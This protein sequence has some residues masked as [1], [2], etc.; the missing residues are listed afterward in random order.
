MDN[1]FKEKYGEWAVVTG[2]SSGIGV[3]FSHQIAARGLNVVLVARRK[4]LLQE[5]SAILIEK[6]KIEVRII[7][8]DLSID[9]FQTAI[10]EG[11]ND[12]DVGLLVNNA[13]IN[14]EGQV[15]RRSLERNLQMI[16]VNMKAPYILAYEYGKIFTKKGKGGIIFT[17][18]ISA[19]NANPY[20]T[21]YAATKAY[22]LSLAEGMHYELKEK[23]IDVLALC[24]G[25]TK[26]EM[27]HGLKDSMLLM[28]A[29]PVASAA[30]DALGKK[31]TVIPGF[32]NKAQ[33][34]LNNRILGR[35][36]AT[37][38]SGAV[39]KRMMPGAASSKKK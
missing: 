27:T 20:L 3:E 35:W 38:L 6:Y 34:F 30:L 16:Q 32:I 21:N 31:I 13:G 29:A 23:N 11:T 1:T 37:E 15:F 26:S 10:L 14:C 9:G 2:A 22:I 19:F 36:G 8:A 7:E 4:P 39:L 12:L 28:E 5:L 24:P 18:S 33:V 17:S 25:F